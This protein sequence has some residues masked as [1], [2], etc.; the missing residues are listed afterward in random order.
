MILGNNN[1]C[2]PL[3]HSRPCFN[4]FTGS[5]KIVIFIWNAQ[6]MKE[7]AVGLTFSAVETGSRGWNVSASKTSSLCGFRSVGNLARQKRRQL[8]LSVP[9]DSF[10]RHDRHCPILVE[11]LFP[12]LVMCSAWLKIDR[13]KVGGAFKQTSFFNVITFCSEIMFKLITSFHPICF[14][15]SPFPA[16]FEI[17]HTFLHICQYVFWALWQNFRNSWSKLR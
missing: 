15:R 10:K 6:K 16:H 7:S 12:Q 13:Q 3:M 14:V 11:P 2:W 4:F 9:F 5:A 8:K 17:F 1:F